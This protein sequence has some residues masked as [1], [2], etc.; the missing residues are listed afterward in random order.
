M[1]ENKINSH[2]EQVEKLKEIGSWLR[3]TRTEQSMS[4]DDVAKQT[5]IQSRLL[6][7]IEEG[8]LELLPEPIYIRSFIK[9]FA[10]ALGLNGS[11]LAS[12]FPTGPSLQL[13]KSSWRQLPAAQLRPL[14]LYLI[15][16][17]VVVASV[18]GL[19]YLIN[20]SNEQVSSFDT[21]EPAEV[22]MRAASRRD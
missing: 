18:S 19:S 21:S 16:I 9:Q 14:H 20:R 1:K 2:Q 17:L 11:E 6:M 8:E 12:A 22:Q 7:A 15:Y 3:Q 5:R 4:I 10:D 13:M